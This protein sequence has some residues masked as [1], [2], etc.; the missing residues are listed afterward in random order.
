MSCIKTIFI[1]IFSKSHSL[2]KKVGVHKC[3]T[4]EQLL[5]NMYMN[6][7]ACYVHNIIQQSYNDRMMKKDTLQAAMAL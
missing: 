3:I 6:C 5:E 7:M 1:V 4:S 2:F